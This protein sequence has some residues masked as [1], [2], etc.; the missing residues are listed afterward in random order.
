MIRPLRPR[1]PGLFGPGEPPP[2]P[3]EDPFVRIRNLEKGYREGPVLRVVFRDLSLCIRRGESVALL[4]RS[5][6]GKSTLLNLVAGIDVPDRGDVYV[7]GTRLQ[8]LSETDRTRFRRRH[9]GI[10]F[11]S[12]NLIPTLT[13]EENVRLPLELLGAGRDEARAGASEFLAK[14]GMGDRG[15]SDPDRLSGGEQQRIGIARALVHGPALLLADEPTGNLDAETG[16]TVTQLMFGLARDRGMTLIVA[17]HSPEV[18]READRVLALGDG[19]LREGV[20]GG[21]P[22]P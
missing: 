19:T 6:S 21:N 18:A 8:G 3:S 10:V 7:A 13:V 2:G 15:D 22:V 12:F 20:P 11:Q 17:T 1:P 5:G 16:R 9:I 4:G 14:V